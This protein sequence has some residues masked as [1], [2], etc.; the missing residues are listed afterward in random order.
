MDTPTLDRATS[1]QLI[2]ELMWR[3]SFFGVVVAVRTDMTGAIP[4]PTDP[5]E[6]C[7]SQKLPVLLVAR[8]LAQATEKVIT[9]LAAEEQRKGENP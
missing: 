4:K 7:G 1:E 3:K 8:I 2:A 9:K 5:V 6:V